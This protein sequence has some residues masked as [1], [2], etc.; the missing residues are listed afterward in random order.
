[1][2]IFEVRR[3]I[4]GTQKARLGSTQA[5]SPQAV[6]SNLGANSYPGAQTMYEGLRQSAWWGSETKDLLY[7]IWLWHDRTRGKATPEV[8]RNSNLYGYVPNGGWG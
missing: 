8:T 4:L 3:H 5:V 1:M 7:T 6:F 2:L